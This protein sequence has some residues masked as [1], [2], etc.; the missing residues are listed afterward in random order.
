MIEDFIEMGLDILDPIQPKAAGMEL[1]FLKSSFG[2]RLT[3]HGG[4]AEQEMLPR[5]RA[6]EVRIEVERLMEILGKDGGYIV[7]A[8][9]AIQS[10]TPVENILAIYEAVKQYGNLSIALNKTI[11]MIL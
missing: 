4:V 6:V 11:V 7:C 8:A 2:T 1:E 3:F 10:D 9:H 5:G